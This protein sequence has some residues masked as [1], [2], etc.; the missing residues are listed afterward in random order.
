MATLIAY[1]SQ[2]GCTEKCATTLADKLQDDATL[3][4]LKKDRNVTLD[5]YDTVLIGGSI[6]AGR[7]QKAVKKFCENNLNVLISKCTG[8][9]LC[10]METGEN[11]QK[12]F[13][14]AFPEELRE[15]AKATGLFGGAFD[16]AKMGFVSKT[17]IKKISKVDKSVSNINQE[18]IDA[19]A[20]QINQT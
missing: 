10:C 16:F 6:H 14:N 4:N 9:F 8:L 17:I 12:Q 15:R 20:E 5:A 19:F 18:S 7:I 3:V 1:V 13:E 11:A 2:H